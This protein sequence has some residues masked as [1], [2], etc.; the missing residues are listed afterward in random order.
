[1]STLVRAVV[2]GAL[3][4]GCLVDGPEVRPQPVEDEV[5]RR[6]EA[7]LGLVTAGHIKSAVHVQMTDGIDVCT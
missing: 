1:M 6:R 4:E 5:V 2:G 3:R 7:R